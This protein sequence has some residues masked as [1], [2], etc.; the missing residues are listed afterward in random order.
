M[1]ILKKKN[2]F[3]HYKELIASMYDKMVFNNFFVIF[4]I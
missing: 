3:F 4:N 1:D 2:N